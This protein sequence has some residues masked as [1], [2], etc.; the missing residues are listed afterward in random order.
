MHHILSINAQRYNNKLFDP[1]FEVRKREKGQREKSTDICTMTAVPSI[2]P[3]LTFKSGKFASAGKPGSE[4]GAEAVVTCHR[5]RTRAPLLS[6]RERAQENADRGERHPRGET[7]VC[8]RSRGRGREWRE[9]EGERA[10]LW[11]T[12]AA[13]CKCPAFVT[14][15]V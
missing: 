8:G 4:P 15:P 10:A 6:C 11:R 13:K 7:K 12:L 2:T 5:S 14:S 3:K 9:G 1:G